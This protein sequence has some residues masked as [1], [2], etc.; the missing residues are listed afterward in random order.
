MRIICWQTI[1]M[2]YH[3]L[4]VF[5]NKKKVSKKVS[6]D[7]VAIGALR[8]K[9]FDFWCCIVSSQDPDQDQRRARSDCHLSGVKTISRCAFI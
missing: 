9:S 5:D 3:T 2:K 4:F 8:G 7:A 1:F 6:S